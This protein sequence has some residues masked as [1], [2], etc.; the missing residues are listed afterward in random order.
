MEEIPTAIA[1]A[2]IKSLTKLDGKLYKLSRE[3][4]RP[5]FDIKNTVICCG[6][7][8]PPKYVLDTLSLGPRNVVLEAFNQN[9]VLAELDDLLRFCKKE[10]S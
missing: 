5:L 9:D 2:N 8:S 3:Q 1:F 4:E 10:G 7:K 6:L